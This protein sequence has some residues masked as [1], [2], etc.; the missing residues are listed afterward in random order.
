MMKVRR[1]YKESEQVTWE[2]FRRVRIVF[3]GIEK[4]RIG[5]DEMK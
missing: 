4:Y 3:Y 2:N 5:W 1:S